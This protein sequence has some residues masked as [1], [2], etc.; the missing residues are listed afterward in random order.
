MKSTRTSWLSWRN[1]ANSPSLFPGGLG[2]DVFP[3]EP[4]TP[5]PGP[6]RTTPLAGSERR[7]AKAAHSLSPGHSTRQVHSQSGRPTSQ[8][9]Q[10]TFRVPSRLSREVRPGIIASTRRDVLFYLFPTY[11]ISYPLGFQETK[12]NVFSALSILGSRTMFTCYL[13]I[14]VLLLINTC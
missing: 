9:P 8:S 1:L 6:N 13:H 12:Q 4:E 2:L 7:T 11:N 3:W 5:V 14:N 10:Q